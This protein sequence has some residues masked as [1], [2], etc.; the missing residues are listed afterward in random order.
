MDAVLKVENLTKV[1]AKIGRPPL[2]AVCDVTFSLAAGE[3]LGI[4]GESG[5]GKS[6]VA[7]L[8]CRLLDATEGRI[9]LDGEDVTH[10][11]GRK[12]REA[13]GKMQMVFQTPVESFDPRHTLGDGIG[14]GLRN[15]GRSRRETEAEVAA[16]LRQCGLPPEMA[17]RYPHQVSVGQ[18]QRAAIARALAVRPRLLVCDEATSSLDMLVQREVLDLLGELRRQRGTDLSI[19]FICHDLAVVR[20]FCDRA[21]VMH[22]GRIVDEYSCENDGMSKE[23]K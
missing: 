11:R 14:E 23:E 4:T 9:I 22:G 13:Y 1:F 8:V 17:G 20:E 19:I 3:C 10:A 5:S 7:N 15:A 18:C 6:T 21:I 12:C 2:T 16:L